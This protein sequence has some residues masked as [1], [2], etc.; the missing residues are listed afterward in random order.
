MQS[1]GRPNEVANLFDGV[2]RWSLDC[3][4]ASRRFSHV[5]EREQEAARRTRDSPARLSI[6]IHRPDDRN[7]FDRKLEYLAA[8]ILTTQAAL[9][10]K[11]MEVIKAVADEVNDRIWT[12]AG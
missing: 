11:K 9:D 6:V 2:I 10:S 8:Y 1:H 3:R 7:E 4:H 12:A 5:P